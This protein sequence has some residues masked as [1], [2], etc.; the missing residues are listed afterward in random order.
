MDVK[1]LIKDVLIYSLS[2]RKKI[3][4]LGIIILLTESVLIIIST[5]LNILGYIILGLLFML[6]LIPHS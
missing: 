3:L 6:T 1:E 2:G 4:I 5:S